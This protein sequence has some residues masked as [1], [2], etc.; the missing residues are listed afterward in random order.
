MEIVIDWK[1][2]VVFGFLI[3][4]TLIYFTLVGLD[5]FNKWRNK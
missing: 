3:V 2:V 5:K 1:D 4:V